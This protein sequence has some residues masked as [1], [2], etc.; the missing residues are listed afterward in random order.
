M[1]CQRGLE[2]ALFK[3]IERHLSRMRRS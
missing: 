1:E 3:L 2:D